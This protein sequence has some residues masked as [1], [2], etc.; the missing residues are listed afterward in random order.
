MKKFETNENVALHKAL[1]QLVDGLEEAQ[2][3][4]GS[5]KIELGDDITVYLTLEVE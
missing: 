4:E 3:T 5:A 1:D 2:V